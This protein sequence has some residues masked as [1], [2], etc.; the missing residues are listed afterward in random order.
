MRGLS[1]V[2]AFLTAAAMWTGFAGTA[3]AS[4]L[5][6]DFAMGKITTVQINTTKLPGHKLLQYNSLIVNIGTGPFE[7]AGSRPS[8][9]TPTMAAAQDVYQSVGGYRSIPTSDVIGYQSGEWRLQDLES[10]WLETVG[11]GNVAALA[12]HWYCPGDDV[13]HLPNLP[14]SPSTAVYPGQCGKGQSSLLSIVLGI[15]VGWADNYTPSDA[16]QWIDITNVPNGIYYLYAQADPNGY[17]TEAN[18]SNNTTW[19]K[20]KIHDTTVTILKYGPYV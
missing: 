5:L 8:T 12:K 9:T 3:S 16:K 18:K 15:S 17:F 1:G 10:G 7:I 19:D 4:D 14:G 20:I 11:G 13:H 2:A 6:P